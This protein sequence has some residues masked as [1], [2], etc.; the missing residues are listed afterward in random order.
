MAQEFMEQNPRLSSV[1]RGLTNSWV[2][3][4]RNQAPVVARAAASVAVAHS[5]RA[6]ASVEALATFPSLLE[7]VRLFNASDHNGMFFN[8]SDHHGMFFSWENFAEFE[9]TSIT[10]EITEELPDDVHSGA[11]YA[12]L[13]LSLVVLFGD[14]AFGYKCRETKMKRAANFSEL[15]ER[16]SELD[17]KLA[18]EEVAAYARRQGQGNGGAFARRRSTSRRDHAAAHQGASAAV[19]RGNGC[20]VARLQA[21]QVPLPSPHVCAWLRLRASALDARPLSSSRSQE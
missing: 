14:V 3:S 9:G 17:A 21:H 13:G 15:S 4:A 19:A 2:N 10:Q 16:L 12:V 18:Q 7:P 20:G 11:L 8:A 1:L 6:L 5:V